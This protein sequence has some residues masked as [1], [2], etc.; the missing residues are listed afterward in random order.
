M[1]YRCLTPTP[2]PVV[3]ATLGVNFRSVQFGSAFFNWSYCVLSVLSDTKVLKC[4]IFIF[5]V[6]EADWA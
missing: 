3:Q 1:E 2:A 4:M 5:Y 6:K